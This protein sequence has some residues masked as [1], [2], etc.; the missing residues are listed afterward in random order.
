MSYVDKNAYPNN[1]SIFLEQRFRAKPR[2]GWVKGD[3]SSFLKFG[4]VNKC[5]KQG[6]PITDIK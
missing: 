4:V 2:G 6:T 3:T 1:C 5:I